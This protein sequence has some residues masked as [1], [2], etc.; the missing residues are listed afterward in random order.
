MNKFIAALLIVVSPLLWAKSLP[1]EQFVKHG[2]YR[3]MKISPD[4]KHLLGQIQQNDKVLLVFL[5]IETMAIVGG[6]EPNTGD[7]IHTANWINNER[8]VYE[9]REKQEYIDQPVSTGE[10]FA[11]NID[12]TQKKVL[13]G[14][15]A[16][17]AKVGSRIKKKDDSRATQEIVSLLEGDDDH[18]MIIEHPWTK[19]GKAWYDNRT[20][21]PTLS[22]LNIYTGRKYKIETLPYAGARVLASID[23]KVNFVSYIDNQRYARTA[24]RKNAES[25][26]VDIKQAFNLDSTLFPFAISNDG[27]QAYV[28]NS[29][30]ENELNNIFELDIKSG[31][32]T[33]VFSNI[34]A[35]IVTTFKDHITNQPVV[36]LSYPNKTAYHYAKNDSKIKNTHKML[37][38]AFAGQTVK[39]SSSSEDGNLLIVHVSSDV[40]PGEFYLFNQKT[41]GADF[42]WANKSWFDPRDMRSKQPFVVTTD[43]NLELNGYITMPANASDEKPPMVVMVH[44]GP[45]ARDYWNFDSEVQL[46]ANKGY[47]VLQVNYRGSRGYGDVFERMSYGEWGSKM[48]DDITAATQWAISE[49]KTNADRICIYGASYGGYAALMSVVREPELYQCAV[50]YVG[51]YDLETAFSDSNI[52]HLMGGEAY[53][54]RELTQDPAILKA[55]SPVNHA[56]KIKA[57]VMLVHGAEDRR[58]PE[59]NSARMKSRLEAVGKEVIYL[60]FSKSGHGVVSEKDNLVLYQTMLDFLKKNIGE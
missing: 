3:E 17:D 14:Y 45:H 24:Y 41:K 54:T 36:A 22:K 46:L 9:F 59:I 19:I 28:S 35:D 5:N 12:G 20:K 2:D 15:R 40:N 39:I 7:E 50:G 47:A 6:V 30:G 1:L 55:N 38:Q 32:L 49:G 34:K 26:W 27:T 52:T 4:G 18:I 21:Q 29:I 58:V 51:P 48:I 8:V 11:T 44:G 31:E 23:G 10:L 43:D 56:D 25:E 53:L 57:E 13:Y 16:G 37:V 33:A 60:N 42:L